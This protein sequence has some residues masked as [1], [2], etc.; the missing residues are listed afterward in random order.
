MLRLAT[1]ASPKVVATQFSVNEQRVYLLI[2]RYCSEG[3]IG[4]LEQPRAGRPPKVSDK[5]GQLLLSLLDQSGISSEQFAKITNELDIS[6]DVIWRRARLLSKN[7]ARSIERDRTVDVAP[8]QLKG[9]IG[10]FLSSDV[11]IS[12]HLP[13]LKIAQ[14]VT[15]SGKWDT[16][17][18]GGVSIPAKLDL[19]TALALTASRPNRN[20][21]AS[22]RRD[23]QLKELYER[24]LQETGLSSTA[25]PLNYTVNF[26]GGFA[27]DNNLYCL[28]V[29]KRCI[30]SSKHRTRV[31]LTTDVHHWLAEVTAGE[32]EAAHRTQ[33][34]ER[35]QSIRQQPGA[36]FAWSRN[37]RD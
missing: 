26:T 8:W 33:F 22:F 16:S 28:Q 5:G 14:G 32:K 19:M 31:C 7:L 4:L 3:L 9:V 34:T 15:P 37:L 12:L 30:S 25:V 2:D 27:T 10:V 36:V 24:W 21:V 29:L 6:P 18:M 13:N 23:R 11:S 20:P 1:G 17:R 35:F